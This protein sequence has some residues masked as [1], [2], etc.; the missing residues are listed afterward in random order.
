MMQGAEKTDTETPLFST[1]A[2]AMQNRDDIDTIP[3]AGAC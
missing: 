3:A 1:E 2:N